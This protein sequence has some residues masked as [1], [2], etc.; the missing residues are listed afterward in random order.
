MKCGKTS[1]NSPPVF[2]NTRF[3]IKNVVVG[4]T[5]LHSSI[6]SLSRLHNLHPALLT[7]SKLSNKIISTNHYKNI[8]REWY[9]ICNDVE[10]HRRP[11]FLC[12]L[13]A[14]NVQ[15]L[16]LWPLAVENGTGLG[17]LRNKS[18]LLSEAIFRNK[19]LQYIFDVP[20]LISEI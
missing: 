17:L 16:N 19:G 18:R 20:L 6:I 15:L 14:F 11:R 13:A 1:S 3:I 4:W 12:S 9:I 8:S 7:V 5:N 2:P 10:E